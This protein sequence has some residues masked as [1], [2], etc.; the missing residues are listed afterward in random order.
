MKQSKR[1][2]KEVFASAM[3]VRCYKR[4]LAEI[5]KREAQHSI[6]LSK[7]ELELR[8]EFLSVPKGLPLKRVEVE[9]TPF[10]MPVVEHE[11]PKP[12]VRPWAEVLEDLRLAQYR[13]ERNIRARWLAR[14][15]R[16][17]ERK[18]IEVRRQ[19]L[20]ALREIISK[21]HW[22]AE[23]ID[24]VKY[25]GVPVFEIDARE[26]KFSE[27]KLRVQTETPKDLSWEDHNLPASKVKE[28]LAIP[29]PEVVEPVNRG[30]TDGHL[31]ARETK[32]LPSFG[33][34]DRRN[35]HEVVKGLHVRPNNQ[36][37]EK[38]SLEVYYSPRREVHILP[39][40]LEERMKIV[41][42]AVKGSKKELLR[43]RYMLAKC[44]KYLSLDTVAYRW[45]DEPVQ[46]TL[47]DM[48]NGVPSGRRSYWK[49]D[50][51]SLM[52]RYQ[53][54]TEAEVR[55]MQIAWEVF[56]EQEMKTFLAKRRWRSIKS[57]NF[58]KL[59][60]EF[61]GKVYRSDQTPRHVWREYFTLVNFLFGDNLSKAVT[62]EE[63][64]VQFSKYLHLDE[65]TVSEGT[66]EHERWD[67]DPYEHDL[68][69]EGY[70]WFNRAATGR[71]EID[72]DLLPE[73]DEEANEVMG[74]WLT[75]IIGQ[76]FFREAFRFYTGKEKEGTCL[77]V[78][79]KGGEEELKKK[80]LRLFKK[81]SFSAKE[82][83]SFGTDV[84]YQETIRRWG[85]SVTPSAARQ[86][87]PVARGEYQMFKSFPVLGNMFKDI[88]SILAEKAVM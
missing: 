81:L 86:L 44:K 76:R 62:T 17:A 51:F 20:R 84:R 43:E 55:N 1:N 8:R 3:R 50:P 70:G 9:T 53:P 63:D 10:T 45:E 75:T 27:E 61:K 49:V 18:S 73:A 25:N 82:I 40:N 56:K 2:S 33:R 36:V 78:M 13:R 35:Y 4:T 41:D 15:Q 59:F 5:K 34:F 37:V 85:K 14:K 39:L 38:E 79:I 48:V 67:N 66:Y 46:R 71:E 52:R 80:T 47:L 64:E 57:E 74:F 6:A 16:R 24:E 54:Q 23:H 32:R 65:V 88:G 58:Q 22:C 31:P 11:D 60:W 69:S 87:L 68:Y 7:Q 26:R 19:D 12:V 21:L 42:P 29:E 30:W 72:M 83:E 77:P 28:A